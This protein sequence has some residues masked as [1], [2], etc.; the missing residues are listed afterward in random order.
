MTKTELIAEVKKSLNLTEDKARETLETVVELIKAG[1]VKD[2]KC[3]IPGLGKLAVVAVPERTYTAFGK[4]T[5]KPAHKK[6]ALDFSDET[7]TYLNK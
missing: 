7:Y 5:T 4:Q 6:F 1:A 2:G 3:V